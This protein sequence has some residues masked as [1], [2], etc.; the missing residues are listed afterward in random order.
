ML[1]DGVR[2]YLLPLTRESPKGSIRD[3]AHALLQKKPLLQDTGQRLPSLG[4]QRQ[5]PEG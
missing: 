2:R 4:G 1:F 5:S 3:L